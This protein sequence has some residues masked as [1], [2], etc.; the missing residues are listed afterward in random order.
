LPVVGASGIDGEFYLEGIGYREQELQVAKTT[1][2]ASEVPEG[3]KWASFAGSTHIFVKG[4]GLVVDNPEAH[5]I[6][7]RATASWPHTDAIVG[8]EFYA[9]PMTQDDGF[10]SHPLN[11]MITYRTPALWDLFGMDKKFFD[12][13]G[14]MDLE[15]SLI[16]HHDLESVPLKCKNSGKCKL[17]YKRQHTPA[18]HYISPR[19]VYNTAKTE[20]WFDPRGTTGLITD[21]TEEDK[22]F[23]NARVSGALVD[24]EGTV[25]HLTTFS[26]WA[27]NRVRG[28][29]GELPIGDNHTISMLWE[30]G[31]AEILEHHALWC[32]YNNETCYYAKNIPVIF[33]MDQ[34]EGLTTGGQNL[35][36]HGHGFG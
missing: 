8:N 21:L 18:L 26:G 1:N 28:E 20:F 22:L 7:L 3:V 11:G 19:V 35:T 12:Q 24:F 17:Y 2:F 25:D 32:D 36:V 31:K 15:L 30:T 33:S 10:N 23:I 14:S 13:Y 16:A 6:V 5:T 4:V 9:P 34:S 27:K 29:V